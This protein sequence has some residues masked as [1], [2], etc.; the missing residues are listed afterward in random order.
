MCQLKIPMRLIL[1]LGLVGLFVS[2]CSQTAPVPQVPPGPGERVGR[3]I[4]YANG[5][6]LDTKTQLM[7]A[8]Q[9]FRNLEGKAPYDY[10]WAQQW[11]DKMNRRNYGGHNDWRMPSRAEYQS[12]YHAEHPRRSYAGQSIGCPAVFA[13]AGGE[14]YWTSDVA[15]WGDP[16]NHIHDA[17]TF[18]FR[19][20]EASP[21]HTYPSYHTWVGTTLEETGS[22]RLVRSSSS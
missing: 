11:V 22:V 3:F 20:G 4:L 18:S 7:W 12:L 8:T 9:D 6:A 1:C 19:T 5:T 21:R 13:D 10:E 2:A 17:W 14:W 15:E 16:P